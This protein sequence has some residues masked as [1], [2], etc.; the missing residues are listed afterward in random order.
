MLRKVSIGCGGLFVILIM[1][2]IIASAASPKATPSSATQPA[3]PTSTSAPVPTAT[4]AVLTA[5]KP[6]APPPKPTAIAKVGQRVE[7]AGV[8]ITVNAV[9]R[10]AQMSAPGG[11]TLSPSDPSHEYVITDV[12]IEN[13]GR[14]KLPY[15]PLYFK[16]KDADGYEY[17][18]SI[19][20]DSQAL[21]SGELTPGDKARGTVT[22][23]VPKTSTSLV[24]SY[25][26]LVLFGGYQTIS[27]SLE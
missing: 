26:P 14:E 16:V 17:N 10:K 19:S 12:T 18:M 11:F 7:S 8:A 4:V 22:F 9:T 21:K 13:A 20:I 24:A 23:E 3:L 15:N 6:L 1:L 25:K 2:G 5:T 27:I